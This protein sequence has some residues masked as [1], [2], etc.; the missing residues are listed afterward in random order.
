MTCR[1]LT[2]GPPVSTRRLVLGEPD[3]PDQEGESVREVRPPVGGNEQSRVRV[4][5]HVQI[6][7]TGSNSSGKVTEIYS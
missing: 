7:W 6:T 5:D 2:M 3:L 4:H 1:L